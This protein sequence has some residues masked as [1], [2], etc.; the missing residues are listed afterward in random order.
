MK[1]I[2]RVEMNRAF[3]YFINR[4]VF[5]YVALEHTALG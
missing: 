4:K 5:V 1:Q 2:K 3:K